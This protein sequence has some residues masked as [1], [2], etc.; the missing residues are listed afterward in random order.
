MKTFTAV[1]AFALAALATPAYAQS[2]STVDT[3]GT[4]TILRPVTIEQ[5]SALAFGTIVR[6]TSGSSTIAI[7]TGADTASK[8]GSAVLLRGPTSRA[9]YTLRGEG[10]ETV[11][12]SMPTSFN[13]TKVG[14][15][16]TL[17]VALTRN[18]S[19]TVLLGSTLGNEG[20]ATLDVGGSF[21][22]NDATATGSYTGTFPVSVSYN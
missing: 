20:T 6:P 3:T 17:G 8:T 21:T 2:T 10:G 9:R 7:G 15:A 13:M 1:A 5:T 4:T 12:V 16:D 19:G 14:A 22:I 18:P 11:S